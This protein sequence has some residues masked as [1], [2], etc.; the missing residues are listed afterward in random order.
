MKHTLLLLGLLLTLTASAQD[1]D[2]IM[3][4]SKYPVIKGHKYA[5]V[6]PVAGIDE[7]PDPTL[8]YN[9]V[10]DATGYSKDST[11]VN[12]VLYNIGRIYNLH[13]EAGIP[14]E[15]INIVVA[16]HNLAG[17][18]FYTNK[19]YQEEYEVENPNVD[20]INELKANGVRFLMCG[21]SLAFSGKKKN[22]LLPGTNV[23][24]TAQTTITSYQLKGYALLSMHNN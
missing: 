14:K 18:A 21:Q 17:D 3:S 5:G 11:K 8:Q 13:V 4:V 23:T 12:W 16:L 6:L 15:Q 20:L 19:V 24:L 2:S 7:K 9:I 1:I 22:D 10:V